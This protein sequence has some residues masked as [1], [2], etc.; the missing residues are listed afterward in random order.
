MNEEQRKSSFDELVAGISS[1]E[2][3]FLLAKINQNRDQALPILQPLRED[4]DEFTLDIKLRSESLFYKFVL[5][6][7]SLISHKQKIELYNQDLVGSIARKINKNHPG[8][9]DQNNGLLQSLFYDKLKELKASAD[10]FKPYFQVMADNPGKFYVF[11]SAFI[12]PEITA[13]ITKDADPYS[14]PFDREATVELRTSLLKRL[15]SILKEIPSG[16]KAKLYAAVKS[17]LWLKRF[18]ELSYMHFLAQFTAIISENYTCP[19]TNAQTDFPALASVLC[20]AKPIPNDALEALFL[21][22]QRKGGAQVELDGDT[23]KSMRE[24]LSKSASSISM[25]QMFISTVPMAQLGK[26]IFADYDW[27]VDEFGGGE[28]WFLKFKEEW[29]VVF[30]ERWEGWLRDRK[31]AQ[32]VVRLNEKFDVEKF[33]ELPYRPWAKLWGGLTFRCELTGGFMFWFAANKYDELISV[34]NILVL[35]G[36]FNNNENRAEL[37]EALNKFAD[38]NHSVLMFGESLSEGGSVG[39]VFAKLISEHS[40]TLKGQNLAES[41]ILNGETSIRN[42]ESVF[43][44]ACRVIECIL[45]GILDEEK[46][47]KNYESLQN[48]TTIRGHENREFRDKLDKAREELNECRNILAEIEPLDLPRSDKKNSGR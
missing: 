2:R 33:P 22:P 20:E 24:F 36:V 1:D 46:K 18:S 32:L 17:I 42:W 9:V 27:Q 28:D 43:C 29:K 16:S 11:M 31:K 13:S 8:I 35:E 48:L 15:D 37:S 26:V 7:R 5:W 14:V 40:R 12:A 44:D 30:D 39:S 47:D 25:I 38:V 3:K 19:Y 21:Y 34:L 4:V 6:L 23:E 45:S 41:V 10:F